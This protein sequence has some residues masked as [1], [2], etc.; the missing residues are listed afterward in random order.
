ML[1][2]TS[3][4]HTASN[5]KTIRHTNASHGLVFRQGIKPWAKEQAL[6]AIEPM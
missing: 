3:D 4:D 1:K 5:T 6:G 2:L